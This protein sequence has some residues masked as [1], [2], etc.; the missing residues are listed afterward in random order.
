MI[1]EENMIYTDLTRKAMKFAYDA[2]HGSLDKTGVPYIYH[3][4][5]L[6]EQMDTEYA[7]CAALLHDVV[8]DTDVTLEDLRAEGFPL[9]VVVAVGLLTHDPNTDYL[10]FVRALKDNPIARAVKLAD[11]AHNS[12]LS[13]WDRLDG[14]D[15]ERNRKYAAA[16]AILNDDL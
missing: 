7:C 11:L 4:M 14:Q 6:A 5:H 9:P 2:H 13:R 1:R 10:D 16:K 8:E 3:P 15:I 12:D